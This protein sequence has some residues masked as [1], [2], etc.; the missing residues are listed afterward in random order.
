MRRRAARRASF[1]V[2]SLPCST[3]RYGTWVQSRDSPSTAWR[4][5]AQHPSRRPQTS[6][7]PQM[8]CRP[9][10]RVCHVPHDEPLAAPSRRA[11]SATFSSSASWPTSWPAGSLRT[12]SHLLAEPPL[13]YTRAPFV[14]HLRRVKAVEG[15]QSSG[16]SVP[17]ERRQ[18]EK[19][20]RTPEQ[21]HGDAFSHYSTVCMRFY[22]KK[23]ITK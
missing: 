2:S 5:S 4:G 11:S 19:Q 22:F 16:T 23:N 6:L 18:R 1:S 20:E 3:Q 7:R 14:P 21:H 12:G 8:Q 9:H 13:A 10:S 17:D 15:S